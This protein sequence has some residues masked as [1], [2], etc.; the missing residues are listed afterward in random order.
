MPRFSLDRHIPLVGCISCMCCEK[1]THDGPTSF[2]IC[3]DST[4][5]RNVSRPSVQ[6][7]RVSCFSHRC[8]RAHAHARS[9][10]DDAEHF[11]GVFNQLT[12][13]VLSDNLHGILS[14][15]LRPLKFAF[16]CIIV[17]IKMFGR[18][19]RQE[20]V[21]RGDYCSTPSMVVLQ[22]VPDACWGR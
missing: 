3:G 1:V 21:L 17:P 16:D 18:F 22:Q 8:A 10:V 4:C 13:Q 9:C 2:A 20:E 19:P 7:R 6:P 14:F 5:L 12:S 15:S 11:P